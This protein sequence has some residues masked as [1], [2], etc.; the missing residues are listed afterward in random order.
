MQLYAQRCKMIVGVKNKQ[1]RRV[2][3]LVVSALL[4]ML[5]TSCANKHWLGWEGRLTKTDNRLALQTGG[6]HAGIW[7]TRDIAIH[8]RYVHEQ[9]RLVI[10]GRVERQARLRYYHR[11]RAWVWIHFM[12]GDGYVKA[13]RR[14]WAQNG[15]DV[16]AQIRYRFNR[17]WQ[18]PPGVEA[19]GFSYS[20]RA[21]DRDMRWDFWRLP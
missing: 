16:Y 9:D 8:Y 17:D 11:L 3:G 6:P 20:G 10:T 7:Q 15:S 21:S 5:L 1:C 19:I 13:S 14:L 2:I 4:L 12:D 18:M